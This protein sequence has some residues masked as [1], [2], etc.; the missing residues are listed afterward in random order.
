MKKDLIYKNMLGIKRKELINSFNNIQKMAWEQILL[1][2]IY[3]RH[4]CYFS[5]DNKEN[6]NMLAKIKL[7]KALDKLEDSELMQQVLHSLH[8]GQGSNSI[9]KLL[10]ELFEKSKKNLSPENSLLRKIEEDNIAF[11]ACHEKPLY[12]YY[13][14]YKILNNP[15][16]IFS[17]LL[18]IK[19]LEIN[20]ERYIEIYLADY[21]SKKHY[22]SRGTL[23][24][25]NHSLIQSLTYE[26]TL[27]E[28]ISYIEDNQ[29]S[30]D[31]KTFLNF[32][33]SSLSEELG[34]NIHKAFDQLSVQN[35]QQQSSTEESTFKKLCSLE[36]NKNEI[37]LT[38]DKNL[39]K[40]LSGLGQ[41]ESI[42]EGVKSHLEKSLT[43]SRYTSNFGLQINE[44]DTKAY[45]D[46]SSWYVANKTDLIRKL[47]QVPKLIASVIEFDIRYGLGFC[48]TET[49]FININKPFKQS[50]KDTYKLTTSFIKECLFQFSSPF[51]FNSC[52]LHPISFEKH[53]EKFEEICA[54]G[55]S[56]E[57]APSLL[58]TKWADQEEKPMIERFKKLPKYLK[59]NSYTPVEPLIKEQLKIENEKGNYYPLNSPF[60]LPLW[61]NIKN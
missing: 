20:F 29:I 11:P 2:A 47:E 43:D 21:M 6:K 39:L 18:N 15:I 8:D 5:L 17:E 10:H 48:N 51:N 52:G 19:N 50:S 4:K 41:I 13:A 54:E 14:L 34:K 26:P 30:I 1:L 56:E 9:I 33:K 16:G 3:S 36:Q 22:F 28:L 45:D 49:G 24:D 40:H 59:V 61:F 27:K 37:K 32:V 25:K 31:K 35:I 55:N 60:P 46:V 57:S 12:S 58:M 38:F 42:M 44:S 53:I 23:S 7:I